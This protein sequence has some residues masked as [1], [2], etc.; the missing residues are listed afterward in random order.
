MVEEVQND[1]GGNNK[2][3]APTQFGSRLNV[4]NLLIPSKPMFFA[5]MHKTLCIQKTRVSVSA[6]NDVKCV[7]GNAAVA[8]SNSK[9]MPVPML[10]VMSQ[11]FLSVGSTR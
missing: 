2:G 8:S 7:S 4:H 11:L 3:K 10:L 5:A 6:D 1:E 9:A